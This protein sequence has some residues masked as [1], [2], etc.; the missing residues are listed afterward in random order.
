MR[1]DSSTYY[2]TEETSI[3]KTSKTISSTWYT[4]YLEEAV[5]K[6]A[7][8]EEE[9]QEKKNQKNRVKTKKAKQNHLNVVT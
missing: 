5:K 6:K 1:I 7:E 2:K 9:N 8:A 4:K 3:W